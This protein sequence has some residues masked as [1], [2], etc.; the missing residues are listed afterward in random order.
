MA[1]TSTRPPI[2]R[3]RLLCAC[4]AGVVSAFV[5]WPLVAA[6]AAVAASDEPHHHVI[7]DDTDLRIM[8]VMIPPGTATG[9]HKHAH[10]FVVTVLR[11]SQTRTETEGEAEAAIGEMV[12]DA[13]TF[14]AYGEKAIVHRIANTSTWLNHQLT[15]EILTRQPM[16]YGPADRGGVPD[17]VPLLQNARLKAWRL[18]LAPGAVAAP[19]VQ[20]GPGVRVIL[21]GDRIIDTP[22]HGTATE[23]DIR[24]GDAAYLAP[25][26]RSVANA[27]NGP[28]DLIEFELL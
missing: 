14:G 6:P 22:P 23:T 2:G 19:V 24:A 25:A 8:R 26:T 4:C 20:S 13:V 5:P 1:G 10:D 12:T 28:L 15:F 9:W 16:G 18:K 7:Y 17:F 27:G 3:R 11:G 21:A